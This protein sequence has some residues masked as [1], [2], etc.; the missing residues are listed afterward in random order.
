MKGIFFYFLFERPNLILFPVIRISLSGYNLPAIKV[1]SDV[2]DFGTCPSTEPRTATFCLTN[3]LPVDCTVV[4]ILVPGENSMRFIL[5]QAQVVIPAHDVKHVTLKASFM[6]E[7][8]VEETLILVAYG[9]QI[10]KIKLKAYCGKSFK[11]LED[12]LNFGPTDIFFQG[13]TKKLT[14]INQ[15]KEKS[16]VVSH[17]SSSNEILVNDGNQII[18]SPGARVPIPIEFTSD[19]SGKR[20]EKL[21]FFAP[22]SGGQKIVPVQAMSGP[23]LKVAVHEDVY[24]T[25][26]GVGETTF[27][28]LPITNLMSE[29]GFFNISVPAGVPVKLTSCLF[30][31]SN[32]VENKNQEIYQSKDYIGSGWVGLKVGVPALSTAVIEI[33][34]SGILEGLFKIPLKI[35]MLSPKKYDV[36]SIFLYTFI[37]SEGILQKFFNVDK[38]LKDFFVKPYLV[39]VSDTTVFDSAQEADARPVKTDVFRIEP[40]FQ[41]IHGLTG[42][43]RLES[44]LDVVQLVNMTSETQGYRIN[45]STHFRTTISLE[46]SVPPSSSLEIP[47]RF[48]PKFLTNQETVGFSALGCLAV[49]NTNPQFPSII[50][51]QLLGVIDD[52]LEIEVREI[53]KG[54]KFPEIALNESSKRHILI[55]NKSTVPLH[56]EFNLENTKDETHLS[57][58][59]ISDAFTLGNPKPVTLKAFE[60]FGIEVGFRG[61]AHGDYLAKLRVSYGLASKSKGKLSEQNSI[62]PLTLFG[63]IGNADIARQPDFLSFGDVSVG[64]SIQQSIVLQNNAAVNSFLQILPPPYLQIQGGGAKIE[65]GK[66]K[67]K[68]DLPVLFKPTSSFSFQTQLTL[69]YG[70]NTHSIPILGVSGF[71][72]LTSNLGAPLLVD[73]S[74]AS[75]SPPSDDATFDIGNIAFGDSKKKTIRFFNDGNLD[76]FITKITAQ[77]DSIVVLEPKYSHFVG[78]VANAVLF[79]FGTNMLENEEIDLDNFTYL[80]EHSTK[81]VASR[82]KTG[83]FYKRR[84]S[85]ILNNNKTASKLFADSK[86][87]ELQTEQAIFGSSSLFELFPLRLRPMQGFELTLK[88]NADILG[89]FMTPILLKMNRFRRDPITY[90]VWVKGK[91]IRPLSLETKRIDFGTIHVAEKKVN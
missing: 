54:I 65:V 77:N 15:S 44:S 78:S 18:L 25:P 8:H 46:G 28:R 74:A 22:N 39:S 33:A 84:A 13:V 23:Y 47:I 43:G 19:L 1:S 88:I 59:H 80:M 91:I 76:A 36:A 60:L 21:T 32:S 38:P 85:S 53:G 61:N 73:A 37:Y 31:Y 83:Q 10:V 81:V 35:A 52:L 50:S 48:N 57:G 4:M 34:F 75:P 72:S 2:L 66:S 79:A 55:R 63:T 89:D 6:K 45:L 9:G 64:D 12:S 67:G 82:T 58:V 11:I 69:A 49:V 7:G 26:C 27:L 62:G 86:S 90:A 17:T 30:L 20:V 29:L 51:S 3:V 40:A 16:L 5:P 41:I 70:S 42:S 68:V 24:M 14:F 56:V 71:F 87:L